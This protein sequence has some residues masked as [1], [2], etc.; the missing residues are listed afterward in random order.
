MPIPDPPIE[1]EFRDGITVVPAHVAALIS[2]SEIDPVRYT[3]EEAIKISNEA[4]L[5]NRLNNVMWDTVGSHF[6]ENR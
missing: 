3:Y 4:M 1:M 5:R 2:I 6:R